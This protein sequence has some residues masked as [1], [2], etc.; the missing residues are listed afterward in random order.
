MATKARQIAEKLEKEGRYGNDFSLP[1]DEDRLRDSPMA[2][3]FIKGLS[4]S[5]KELAGIPKF[6]MAR[7]GRSEEEMSELAR[8]VAKGNKLSKGGKASSASRRAD[9]VAQRGKTKGRMC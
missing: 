3:A 1:D 2:G 4:T 7:K 8:E 9:G 5:V 6:L